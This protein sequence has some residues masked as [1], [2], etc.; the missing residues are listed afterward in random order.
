MDRWDKMR[1]Q[2]MLEIC[3]FSGIHLRIAYMALCS[4]SLEEIAE[5]L[6]LPLDQVSSEFELVFWALAV[7]NNNLRE[8]YEIIT[9][10]DV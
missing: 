2:A 1:K 10:E 6:N 9:G 3:K 5:E 7:E 4:K 8:Y